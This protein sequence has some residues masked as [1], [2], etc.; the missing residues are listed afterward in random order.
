MIRL[1]N[2]VTIVAGGALGVSAPTDAHGYLV[3]SEGHSV[4]IDGGSGLSSDRILRNVATAGIDPE[5]IEAIVLTHA[6]WDHARGAADLRRMLGCSIAASPRSSQI[7]GHDRWQHHEVTRVDPSIPEPVP[8]DLPLSD[9]LVLEFGQLRLTAYESPGHSPDGYSFILEGD[10]DDI[11]FTGDTV[12]GDGVL[13]PL[14]Q[15]SDFSGLRSALVRLVDAQPVALMP[16]HGLFSLENAGTYLSAAL[17]T[18]EATWYAISTH[19]TGR[20]PSWWLER[21]PDIVRAQ[22]S[23]AA[24]R[25]PEERA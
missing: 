24:D 22:A 9:G 21:H 4:L 7:L 16:G 18:L 2:S 17:E 13:G 3:S 14:R 12:L 15:D 25:P 1:T 10:G 8:I 19:R 11:V 23:W 20:Y 5:S 6:H